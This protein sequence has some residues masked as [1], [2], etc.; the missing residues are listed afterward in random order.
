MF[1]AS[2]VVGYLWV[3]HPIV[4]VAMDLLLTTFIWRVR[5]P[6]IRHNYFIVIV[7]SDAMLTRTCIAELR[8]F[9][10]HGG[11]GR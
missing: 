10:K 6:T 3:F 1:C 9:S 8:V 7:L 11:L 5:F 4:F 2:V